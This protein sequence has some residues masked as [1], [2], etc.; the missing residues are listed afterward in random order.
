ML[1]NTTSS[2]PDNIKLKK[3]MGAF[4]NFTGMFMKTIEI[5]LN[6][7]ETLGASHLRIK[8][9]ENQSYMWEFIKI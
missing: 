3:S 4:K 8:M 2:T 7:D 9:R 1:K 5:D 6:C